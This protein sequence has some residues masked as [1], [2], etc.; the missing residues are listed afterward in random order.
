MKKHFH[1]MATYSA[2]TLI[3]SIP[4]PVDVFADAEKTQAPLSQFI[5]DNSALAIKPEKFWPKMNSTSDL[6]L[7]MKAYLIRSLFSHQ[8]AQ[9][10]CILSKS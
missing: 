8:N 3:S 4:F 9:A 5:D 6:I 7:L 10:F 2:L 1:K